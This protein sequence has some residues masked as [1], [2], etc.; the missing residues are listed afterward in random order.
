MFAMDEEMEFLLES[1][2]A[3]ANQMAMEEAEMFNVLREDVEQAAED[4]SRALRQKKARTQAHMSVVFVSRESAERL[5]SIARIRR[6]LKEEAIRLSAEILAARAAGS[7][8]KTAGK[9][10]K[11]SRE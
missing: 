4:A 11:R 7:A 1:A 10:K 6:L 2:I 3:H 9:G 8:C 5:Q